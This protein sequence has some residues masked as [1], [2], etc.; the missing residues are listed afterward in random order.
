MLFLQRSD[1]VCDLSGDVRGDGNARKESTTYL[2]AS[3][4]PAS[5][6]AALLRDNAISPLRRL[7]R[8]VSYCVVNPTDFSA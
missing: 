1:G 3:S 4:T 8:E 5:R 6:K 7:T 2:T